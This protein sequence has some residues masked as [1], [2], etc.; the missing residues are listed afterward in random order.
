MLGVFVGVVT[1]LLAVGFTTEQLAQVAMVT[2]LGGGAGLAIGRR[3]SPMALPQTVAALHSVVGLAAMLTSAAVVLEADTSKHGGELTP[4]LLATAYLGVLIGGVTFTGSI[5]AFLKLAGKVS[6]KPLILP[7]R[8]AINVGLVSTNA[9]TMGAFMTMAPAAP[10]IGAAL[11]AGNAVLS[12]IQGYTT[13][14]AIGGADMPVLVT[15][16]NAYSG[17]ALVAEGFMLDNM[18]L[19]ATGSLIG[20]S[21]SILSYIMCQAMNRSL[22][23]V[24]FGGIAT[25]NAVNGGFRGYDTVLTHLRL[26]QGPDGRQDQH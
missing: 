4:L 18:L 19:T 20:A 24:I 23:N 26:D 13:S 15:V 16:L 6:S 2:A 14:A 7:G 11:L 8:H 22:A 21:G 9:L 12:C 1:T 25:N 17:F 10:A 5:V 3:V